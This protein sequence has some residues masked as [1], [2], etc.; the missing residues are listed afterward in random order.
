MVYTEVYMAS[1]SPKVY[2][3]Y[4]ALYILG[5]PMEGLPPISDARKSEL[6]QMSI[7]QLQRSIKETTAVKAKGRSIYRGVDFQAGKWRAT[8]KTNGKQKHLGKHDN[9]E[10]AARAYDRAAIEK[11]GR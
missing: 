8:L 5:K 11:D 2:V 6:D 7:Q 9:E 10:A 1:T 4:R 3:L